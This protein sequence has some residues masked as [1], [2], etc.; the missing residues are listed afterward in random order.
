MSENIS[1]RVSRAVNQWLKDEAKLWGKD[2]I[3]IPG[4]HRLIGYLI[5]EIRDIAADEACK[6]EG[7]KR[8]CDLAAYAERK[9]LRERFEK[10]RKVRKAL[11]EAVSGVLT[12][13]WE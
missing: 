9:R 12:S 10:S 5:R 1:E 2:Y 4:E 8:R 11:L 3:E 6:D 13:E 7:V